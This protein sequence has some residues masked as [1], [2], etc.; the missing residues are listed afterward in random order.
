[1]WQTQQV[2]QLRLKSGARVGKEKISSWYLGGEG[3]GF[4]GS[5]A[6]FSNKQSS[7]ALFMPP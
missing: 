5:E 6:T 1:M 4:L 2:A 3:K 7:Q